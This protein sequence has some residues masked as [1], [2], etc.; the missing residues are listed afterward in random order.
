MIFVTVGTNEARFDRLLATIDG[1]GAG[2][3]LIVQHGPSAIRPAGATAVDF[4]S[5]DEMVETM[6]RARIVVTHAGV[7]SVMTSLLAGKRPIVVPRLHRYGEAVDD[8]QLPWGRRVAEAGLVVLCEDPADLAQ[9][10]ASGGGQL[11][12]QL[13][14]SRRLVGDLREY[15]ATAID[16]PLGD[17]RPPD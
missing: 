5:F 10:V 7:G 17:R 12:V 15:L 14:P 16:A 2:E 8:H 13:R 1:L 6:E 9:V 11:D 4:L 3:E